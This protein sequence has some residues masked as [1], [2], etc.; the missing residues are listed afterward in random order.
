MATLAVPLPAVDAGPAGLGGFADLPVRADERAR[1]VRLCARLTGDV[2]AAED[3]A[4]ETLYEAWRNAHKLRD[5]ADADGRTRWLAAIARNVCMRWARRRGRE[6]A[7][8]APMPRRAGADQDARADDGLLAALAEVPDDFDL[9]VELERGELAALLDRAMGLLPPE[10]RRVLYEQV[11]A[12]SPLAETALRLGL[13]QGAVAMRLQRGKLALRQL[14]VTEFRREAVGL[15]LI[16][17]AAESWQET[18]I[19]CQAC[20]QRRLLGRLSPNRH[21]FW[22]RCS[23]CGSYNHSDDAPHLGLAW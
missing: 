20:G 1:L 6:L 21:E 2:D 22:L 10:T 3:L 16:E 11:V 5:P 14:L 9:E 15:G 8:L 4:Q 7:R 17:E 13:S 12:E 19:W 18:R 23:A